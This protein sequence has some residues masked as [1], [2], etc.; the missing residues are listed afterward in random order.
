MCEC[1]RGAIY[2]R[3]TVSIGS[4]TAGCP[5]VP[6]QRLRLR[7][8]K[9]AQSRRAGASAP[10]AHPAVRASMIIHGIARHKT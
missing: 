3:R 10:R 1:L 6:A 4:Q 5:G 9:G 7:A 2:Q 8:V